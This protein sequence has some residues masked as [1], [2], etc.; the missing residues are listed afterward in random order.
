MAST[1][2]QIHAALTGERS[3]HKHPTKRSQSLQESEIM[4]KH[5]EMPLHTGQNKQT[6]YKKPYHRE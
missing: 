2:A 5:Q 1:S 3:S 6:P 4:V